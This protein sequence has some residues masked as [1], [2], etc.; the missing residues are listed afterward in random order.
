MQAALQSPRGQTSP[1]L[2]TAVENNVETGG[3]NPGSDA[4]W[5]SSINGVET[6]VATVTNVTPSRSK[7]VIAFAYLIRIDSTNSG[8]FTVRIKE[9]A[10]TLHSI[11]TTILNLNPHNLTGERTISDAS[12]GAHTYTLTVDE[13]HPGSFQWLTAFLAAIPVSVG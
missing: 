8:D 1:I 9:G 7:N 2:D 6:T 12:V 11:T 13:S 5:S 10:A 3:V 4:N